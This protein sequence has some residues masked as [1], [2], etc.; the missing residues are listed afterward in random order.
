M[1]TSLLWVMGLVF[2]SA[3][4]W[5]QT[6]A[7]DLRGIYVFTNDVSQISAATA[8]NITASLSIPGMDGIM[9]V[10]GW[11]AIEP[12]MGQY[13]WATLD[14]WINQGI[15]SGKKIGLSIN[16]GASTPAWLFQPGP[17]GA[18]AKALSFTISPHGGATGLCQS[19]TMAAPFDA[20]FLARWD[21]IL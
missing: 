19:L 1:R 17:A 14:Q 20:A 11:D 13:Q 15:S 8:K 3:P 5:T 7:A 6:P 2:L 10:I 21:S 9:V 12:A 18:G 4:A 16:A